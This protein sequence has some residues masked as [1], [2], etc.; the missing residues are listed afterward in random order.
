MNPNFKVLKLIVFLLLIIAGGFIMY[1]VKEEKS[2]FDNC[3][4]PFLFKSLFICI[5]SVSTFLLVSYHSRKLVSII[6]PS[7]QQKAVHYLQYFILQFLISGGMG[8]L[9]AFS[10][11]ALIGYAQSSLGFGHTSYFNIDIYF[12]LLSVVFIQFLFFT[13][14]VFNPVILGSSKARK[15]SLLES[16]YIN[17]LHEVDISQ[18]EMEGQ[19]SGTV[20]LNA[21]NGIPLDEISYIYS[22]QKIRYI[23]SDSQGKSMY[24]GH[25]LIE[26][27]SL[28]PPD[29]FFL[30][31][32]HLIVG[33]KAIKSV[34]RL[35]NYHLELELEPP[36][37]LKLSLSESATKLFKIWY[38]RGMNDLAD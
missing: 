20:N 8:V 35:P 13:V 16:D 30:A 2:I 1:L 26:L 29:E 27:T 34:R 5:L 14:Y 19:E 28:L 22:E 37:H 24:E 10:T 31:G 36:F 3:N 15:H 18:H 7:R 23:Q 11:A 4:D 38:M 33:R 6:L 21:I 17:L 12:V 9:T 25:T 32:R